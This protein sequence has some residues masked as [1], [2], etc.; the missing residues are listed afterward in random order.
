MG[1][2]CTG[3]ES[4]TCGSKDQARHHVDLLP[5]VFPSEDGFLCTRD[6]CAECWTVLNGGDRS[7]GN[8]RKG[9]T[10]EAGDP[11]LGIA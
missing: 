9:A 6:V 5:L 1:S 8:R 4:L 11:V 3:V 10:E 2:Y 7:F